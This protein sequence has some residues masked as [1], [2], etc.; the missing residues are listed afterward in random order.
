MRKHIARLI[1]L[2]FWEDHYQALLPQTQLKP[3]VERI[4]VAVNAQGK[5]Y[6]DFCGVQALFEEQLA[7]DP[8]RAVVELAEF[9]R[10][11]ANDADYGR[12]EKRVA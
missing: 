7:L 8:V 3:F 10:E 9:N 11:A 2:I 6:L 12:V 1:L 5:G 4:D